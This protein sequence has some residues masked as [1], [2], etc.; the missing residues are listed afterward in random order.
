MTQG[1][2]DTVIVVRPSGE[3]VR[4]FAGRRT[5]SSA[6]IEWASE[7]GVTRPDIRQGPW[8]TT[9]KFDGVIYRAT[10]ARRKK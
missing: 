1:A 2:Y 10:Y 9:V 8:G 4:R 6:L 7:N 5:L 3:E